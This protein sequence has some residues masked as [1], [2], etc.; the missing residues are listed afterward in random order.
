MVMRNDNLRKLTIENHKKAERSAF[1]KKLISGTMS[2]QFYAVYLYCQFLCYDALEN[3]ADDF[4][5]L[6]DFPELYRKQ[7]LYDDYKELWNQNNIPPEL[8]TVK[9]YIEYVRSLTDPKKIIAHIYVRHMGDLSGGQ[10]IKKWIPGS[11]TY[12]EF[13]GNVADIKSRFLSKLDDSLADE[14]NH[15][16]E[17]ILNIFEELVAYENV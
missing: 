16:F 6:E 7:K 1:I 10:L 5:L 14:A 3:Q 2:K 12:Y 17:L 9:Q 13:N 15:C 4:G 11:G 8:D